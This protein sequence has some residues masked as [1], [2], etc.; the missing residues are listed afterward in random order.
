MHPCTLKVSVKKFSSSYRG[1]TLVELIA[2]VTIVS[3][4][5]LGALPLTKVVIKRQKE[6]ELRRILREM[7]TAIDRYHDY[8]LS[9]Q[10]EVKFG[11]DGYPPDLETLVKGVDQLNAVDKRIRFLR[12]I[13]I[14]P[15]TGDKEWGLRS[16]QDNWD[17]TTYGG[18]NVYDVYS[19]S[20]G[21]ALDGSK[22]SDW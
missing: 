3:I 4:L 21:I 22:Y 1:L 13:P 8:A 12:R 16:S 17:S 14:D 20:R 18:Q 11:T 9:G 7:R 10:I 6:M 15:M 2:T 5:A 19:K